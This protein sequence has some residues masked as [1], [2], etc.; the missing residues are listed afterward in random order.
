MASFLSLAVSRE[1]GIST[2]IEAETSPADSSS[3]EDEGELARGSASKGFGS[4][5]INSP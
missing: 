4:L 2:G 5:L 1:A 3:L